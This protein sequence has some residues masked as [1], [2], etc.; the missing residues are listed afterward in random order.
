MKHNDAGSSL[1]QKLL[2]HEERISNDESLQAQADA[3]ERETF[4][5]LLPFMVCAI[6]LQWAGLSALNA[7]L[8][9]LFDAGITVV[10][11]MFTTALS[12]A[13]FAYILDVPR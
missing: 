5:E 2:D 13:S 1:A 7:Y 12:L 9:G 3:I 11:G 8:P 4:R 6:L 10:M